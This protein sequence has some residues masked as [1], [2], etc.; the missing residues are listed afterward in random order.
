M[1]G[2][3]LGAGLFVSFFKTDYQSVI[4][5]ILLL[6]RGQVEGLPPLVRAIYMYIY[7]YI[8]FTYTAYIHT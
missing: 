3:R 6:S 7:T 8:H 5:R 4:H 1:R 2:G